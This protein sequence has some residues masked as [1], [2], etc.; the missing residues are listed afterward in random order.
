MKT[1]RILPRLFQEFPGMKFEIILLMDR[2][3]LEVDIEREWTAWIILPVEICIYIH[4][5]LDLLDM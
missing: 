3:P 4:T 5:H 2:S 1:V